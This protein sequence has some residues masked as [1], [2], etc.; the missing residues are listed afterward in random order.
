MQARKHHDSIIGK[1][2]ARLRNRTLLAAFN[3][4]RDNVEDAKYV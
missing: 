2:A 4:L 3:K 1:A